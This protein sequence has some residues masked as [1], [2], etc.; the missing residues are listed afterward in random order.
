[1]SM[2]QKHYDEHLGPVYAWMHGGV[3]PAIE[4]GAAEIDRLG[5][6]R[7][8]GGLAVDLGAG[9]GTHAIPLARR[10][11]EVIAID[12]CAALLDEMKAQEQGLPIETVLGDLHT[13][14]R[15]LRRSPELILCMGD[16]LTHLENEAAVI[17]LI[18]EASAALGS[19]GRLVTT[20]RDYSN[21]LTAE[22]RFIP[23]RSDE[24]RI[25]TCFLE[26]TDS[27]VAVHDVLHEWRDARWRMTVSAYPKLR[28]SPA[29]VIEI[30][31]KNGFSVEH[32]EGSSGMVCLVASNTCT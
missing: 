11:F 23:V 25:L 21:A 8:Q 1:M 12:S 20:F 24:R 16:T 4:R 19:G 29:W 6:D 17:S 18:E 14:H 22:Q 10:G 30:M 15:H 7:S 26:Y 31:E 13:F 9:F 3:L 5:I 28:L 32:S 2:I 27:H